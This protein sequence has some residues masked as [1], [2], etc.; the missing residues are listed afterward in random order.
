MKFNNILPPEGTQKDVFG[1]VE[2]SIRQFLKGINTTIFAYGQTG[3]GKTYS[4]IGNYAPNES[5][6]NLF[7]FLSSKE[8]GILS[9]SLEMIMNSA[10]K[11]ANC[12]LFVSFYQIYNEKIFDL[13][14][15]NNVGQGLEI[16]ESKNGEISIPDL[17]TVEVTKMQEAIQ[18]LMIGLKNRA[19]GSTQANSRSSR[20]HSIFQISLE[21]EE[22]DEVICSSL[23]IVD[24]A[25]S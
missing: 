2:D 18:F 24:L 9:R 1:L 25:G 23:R 21:R 10:A 14:N 4:I 19:T 13:Y 16:R 12:R 3:A 20:S 17:V 8:R 7:N 5:Q 11:E 15:Y 6:E 22:G